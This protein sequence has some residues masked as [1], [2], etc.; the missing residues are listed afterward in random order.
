MFFNYF[1]SLPLRVFGINFRA[2]TPEVIS[3]TSLPNNH[4]SLKIPNG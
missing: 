3:L 4:T 1:L 2:L